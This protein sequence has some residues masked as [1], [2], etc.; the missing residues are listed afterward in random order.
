MYIIA[1]NILA[2]TSKLDSV[3]NSFFQ[4][5]I[6]G[7]NLFCVFCWLYIANIRK[8]DMSVLIVVGFCRLYCGMT[9][10]SETSFFI[11]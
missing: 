2:T 4:K 3:D 7:C 8:L 9:K 6:T 11:Y 10:G 5:N 1:Y